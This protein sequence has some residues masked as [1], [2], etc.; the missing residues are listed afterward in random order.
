[1]IL[2]LSLSL[3]LSIWKKKIFYIP[4]IKYKC[5]LQFYCIIFQFH[6]KQKGILGYFLEN[7]L[8]SSLPSH[9]LNIEWTFLG[10]SFCARP[11]GGGYG[12]DLYLNTMTNI[13][14]YDTIFFCKSFWKL[15]HDWKFLF[16]TDPDMIK[17]K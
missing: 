1:M 2:F 10:F 15:Y 11:D 13:L 3:S 6:S 7:A 12:S 5:I 4:T 17:T 8:P 14:T 16:R 9:H